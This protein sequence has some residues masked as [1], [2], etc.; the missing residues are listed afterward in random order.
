MNH[1]LLACDKKEPRRTL[2]EST[3]DNIPVFEAGP[4]HGRDELRVHMHTTG[5]AV[6]LDLPAISGTGV[7]TA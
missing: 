5:T 6:I 3:V 2:S 7:M 1:L 4:V